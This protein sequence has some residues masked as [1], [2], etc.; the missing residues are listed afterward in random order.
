MVANFNIDCC[1]S[2]LNEKITISV[3]YNDKLDVKNKKGILDNLAVKCK[4]NERGWWIPC[5]ISTYISHFHYGSILFNRQFAYITT[6]EYRR[7]ID[8]MGYCQSLEWMT[9]WQWWQYL[10]L[11]LVLYCNLLCN[12][13]FFCL[14]SWYSILIQGWKT[15]VHITKNAKA[16]AT[17]FNIL[18]FHWQIMTTVANVCLTKHKKKHYYF[19]CSLCNM[20]KFLDFK[21]AANECAIVYLKR[22]QLVVKF[23]KQIKEERL[24]WERKKQ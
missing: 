11:F 4:L 7:S 12:I 1:V 17:F 22:R 20:I 18:K 8:E 24:S 21:E 23:P 16:S 3:Y 9:T 19:K 13:V 2:I 6:F 14:F 10:K 5:K 15:I